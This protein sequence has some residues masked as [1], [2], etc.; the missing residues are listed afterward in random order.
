MARPAQPSTTTVTVAGFVSDSFIAEFGSTVEMV[1]FTDMSVSFKLS[2][3][4]ITVFGG[5]S[6]LVDCTTILRGASGSNCSSSAR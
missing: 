6:V 3:R 5:A 4:V 1:E 2:D